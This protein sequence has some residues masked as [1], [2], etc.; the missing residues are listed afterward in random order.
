MRRILFLGIL[1]FLI[2]D[3][4][5]AQEINSGTPQQPMPEYVITVKYPDGNPVVRTYVEILD[6]NTLIGYGYT[7]EN[8][9]MRFDME[10]QDPTHDYLIRAYPCGQK[11]ESYPSEGPR[12]VNIT[13][14]YDPC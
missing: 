2:I 8:G 4:I 13:T 10:G 14:G 7:N 11:L 6:G 12:L 1:I 5:N 9:V 3:N